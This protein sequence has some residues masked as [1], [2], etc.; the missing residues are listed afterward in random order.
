MLSKEQVLEQ[1]EDFLKNV[2]GD[3][4]VKFNRNGIGCDNYD[5]NEEL[6]SSHV[7]RTSHETF[8]AIVVDFFDESFGESSEYEE[9][10][11]DEL[12]P[13]VVDASGEFLAIIINNRMD[14]YDC[15]SSVLEY[16]IFKVIDITE[17][18]ASF[19]VKFDSQNRG[20]CVLSN[21]IVD[22]KINFLSGDGKLVDDGDLSSQPDETDC[23]G[24][25][26]YNYLESKIFYNSLSVHPG[27]VE[28][29]WRG[30]DYD[31]E[32]A[33]NDLDFVEYFEGVP[34][35]VTEYGSI[36]GTFEFYPQ[37]EHED[38]FC[39]FPPDKGSLGV[40]NITTYEPDDEDDEKETYW[41]MGGYLQIKLDDQ[42]KPKYILEDMHDGEIYEIN[43]CEEVR[44][45]VAKCGKK[46]MKRKGYIK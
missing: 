39:P 17:D 41:D 9:F 30:N 7:F 21:P 36:I 15:H 18:Q 27:N 13:N 5:D 42:G 3:I 24:M 12:L 28:F 38:P 22:G 4:V 31:T 46:E 16:F 2:A 25:T 26:F 43:S 6:T 8:E 33:F 44:A 11:N 34:G 32:D 29:F 45:A 20:S 37:T 14:V 1:L 19:L 10:I 40:V 35:V 23:V